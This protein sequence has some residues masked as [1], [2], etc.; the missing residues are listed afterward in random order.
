M[1]GFSSEEF[2]FGDFSLKNNRWDERYE[3]G[4]RR[5]DCGLW[6]QLYFWLDDIVVILHLIHHDLDNI[7][8]EA[9]MI[10]SV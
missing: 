7:G 8:Y 10:H 2:D 4:V 6:M 5:L 1:F 9:I 3:Y